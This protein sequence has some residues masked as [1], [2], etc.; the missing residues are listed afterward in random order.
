MIDEIWLLVD[1]TWVYLTNVN[2][3]SGGSP[4]IWFERTVSGLDEKGRLVKI[5]FDRIAGTREV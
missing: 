1:G 3:K 2:T 5:N 4:P